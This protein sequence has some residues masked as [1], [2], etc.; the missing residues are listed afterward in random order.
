MYLAVPGEDFLGGA[1]APA[2]VNEAVAIGPIETALFGRAPPTADGA[3]HIGFP[4]GDVSQGVLHRPGVLGLRAGEGT[5]P[6]SLAEVGDELVQQVEL[7]D[8]TPDN[9]FTGVAHGVS[10]L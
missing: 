4:V 10:L 9:F 2:Q 8:G 1:V 5:L 3:D 6:V 7:L